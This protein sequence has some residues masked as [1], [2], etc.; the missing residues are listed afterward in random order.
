LLNVYYE[1][2]LFSVN[3]CLSDAICF[4]TDCACARLDSRLYRRQSVSRRIKKATKY[5]LQ[6]SVVLLGF[7]M[8]LTAVV[9]A[10]RD[11][12]LFTIATIFGTLFLGF[13]IGKTV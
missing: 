5:L 10:G 11:G 2:R 9:K 4:A 13:L 8:N 12:V 1:N 7:G 3:Y 6:A